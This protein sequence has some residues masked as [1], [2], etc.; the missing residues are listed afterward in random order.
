MTKRVLLTGAILAAAL[1]T[2]QAAAQQPPQAQPG[3]PQKPMTAQEAKAMFAEKFKAADADN[4]G[5]LTRQEAEAGMP[6][7]A[8]NFDKIDRKKTGY[9]TQKQVGSYA[10]AKAKQRKT[11]QD[12]SSLN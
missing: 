11:A 2:G 8:K 3:Q 5:K 6:E 7:V 1:A 10:V 9:V 12:P 4:D